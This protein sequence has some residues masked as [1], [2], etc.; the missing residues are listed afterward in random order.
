V[1]TAWIPLIPLIPPILL[2]VLSG[3]RLLDAQQPT[4]P[5]VV[6]VHVADSTHAAVQGADV[7]LTVAG[8]A[9]VRTR[10]DSAG[11]AALR[12]SAPWAGRLLVR[13]L[14]FDSVMTDV[15]RSAADTIRPIEI[16]LRRI[17]E[18]LGPVVVRDRS[19]PLA[20]QPYVGAA[21]IAAS[22]RSML[23]LADVVGKLRPDIAYQSRKCLSSPALGPMTRGSIP[24]G[25]LVGT[26]KGVEVYVNGRH[27]PAEWDPWDMIHAEHIEEVRYVNCFDRSI[28]D[29]KALPWPAV[30]V[31]L[32]PGVDWNLSRGSFVVAS[33]RD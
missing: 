6:R 19:L 32:K 8:S 25:R 7:V 2:A 23:S 30:Y 1:R 15:S 11:L 20:R 4:R 10:T 26:P 18:R 12:V 21:E 17:A 22:S 16:V 5:T 9:A 24:R 13:K 28:P 27:V 31:V 33:P 3:A 14:G 29:L